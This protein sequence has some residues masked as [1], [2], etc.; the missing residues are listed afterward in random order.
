M[1]AIV[2]GMLVQC[3]LGGVAWD[4]GQ[5]AAGLE[6]LGYDVYYLEDSGVPSYS[7]NQQTQ[8][9]E[10]S[11]RDGIKFLRESLA[12]FSP[13]LAERWHYRDY[14]ECGNE[15]GVYGIDER[16]FADIVADAD[17]LINVSGSSILRESYRRCRNKVLIDTDP[18]YNHFSNY[19]K[20]EAA[21]RDR[22]LMGLS[23]HDHFFTYAHG[24]GKPGSPLRDFGFNW[25]KTRPPVLLDAW[26]AEPPNER[27]TTV[28]MWNIYRKPII[29]NGVRYGAK[30]S[31][32]EKI[33]SLPQLVKAPI[34]VAVNGGGPIDRWRSIGW[35]AENGH[36]KSHSMSA[37]RSY[38]QS[39]R[40][41]F[42]VAKNVYVATR[43]GWFSCRTVCY[44][45][46]GLPA[47]VQDTGWTDYIPTGEGLFAFDDVQQAAEA[48]N[49]VESNYAGHCQAAR[50]LAENEFDS[51]LVIADMLNQI[52][53]GAVCHG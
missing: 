13:T 26:S 46:A 36:D 8:Q 45:A 53:M 40:G 34:E 49:A 21:D 50:A 35:L 48:I 2:T 51:D 16:T 14:D 30:E 4:Y 7:W 17:V 6:R 47:V 41:E 28:M 15:R 20:W 31:E 32:F 29:H 25:R 33:E 3:P 24:L 42:S 52:E 43:S 39:S 23:G 22:Q 11:C 37:Y 9:F 18:G 19:P 27:W 44:L 38:V 1:K 5:Y 10:D 12:Q